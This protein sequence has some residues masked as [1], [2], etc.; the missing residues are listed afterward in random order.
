M[1]R[2]VGV[3]GFVHRDA[4][5]HIIATAAEI[6]G[7]EQDRVDDHRSRRVIGAQLKADLIAVGEDVAT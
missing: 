4:I 5:A 2:H 6:G 3:A 7:V 1:A